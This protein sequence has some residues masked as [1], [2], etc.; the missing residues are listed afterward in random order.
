MI[1]TEIIS[2]VSKKLNL[3]ESVINK[4]YRAYWKAIREYILSLPLRDGLT[5]EEFQKLRTS[6]NIPSIG[7]FYVTLDKYQKIKYKFNNLNSNKK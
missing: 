1:Y 2:E 4:T 3:S 6:I 5:D 7:K